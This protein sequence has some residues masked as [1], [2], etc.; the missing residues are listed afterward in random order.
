MN[1]LKKY[2]G[3][4]WMLLSPA[5]VGF[6]FWQAAEKIGKASEAT[7]ANVTLQWSI[8]LII[9][10]PICIGLLIFGYYAFKDAYDHLPE[11]SAEITDY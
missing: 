11:S 9:F 6:L 1:A 3:I 2:L 8:I 4:I 5:I 10:F 7:K